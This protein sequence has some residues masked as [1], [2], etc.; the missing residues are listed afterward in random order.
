MTS[1]E[2]KNLI[3]DAF[4]GVQL[5]SGIGLWE[6][7]AI[8]D[9]KSD[10]E[11]TIER[12]KDEKLDWS[13]IPAD[14]LYRCDA[15]LCYMDAEGV[16][17]HLPAFMV[18]EIDGKTNSGPVFHLTSL[19]DYALAKFELLTEQQ[20]FAVIAFLR[21]CLE[22]RDYEYCYKNIG[23]ALNEYWDVKI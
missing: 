17:F 11:Q 12:L 22:S 8:D 7:E 5:G 14:A 23:R 20:R 15:S 18:A 2:L 19:D 21:W 4:R 10:G 1:Q 6:G 16:R 13:R 3:S 9:Y